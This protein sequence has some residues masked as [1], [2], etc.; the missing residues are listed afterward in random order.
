AGQKVLVVGASNSAVDA[1]LE[2]FRKGAEVS[3]VI[4]GAEL[5]KR[6][7]YW[8]KPDIENRIKAGEV[9]AYFNSS[10]KEIREKEADI[11]TP[12]GLVT[13]ENDFVL[14]M[15]GYRPNFDFLRK[16]GIQLSED[17]KMYPAYLPES[18]ESNM[19]NLYLA[20]V[21]CGGMDTHIWF[22]ENSREHA[23]VIIGKIL[24]KQA[25]R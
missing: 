19:P 11:Q 6:V 20:G 8:V 5:G 13:I 17:E 9:K 10:L 15:T 1:A 23:P 7:K 25:A 2:T 18:M 3:M 21:V 24:E 4:R 14:A 12:E 22:I 16:I